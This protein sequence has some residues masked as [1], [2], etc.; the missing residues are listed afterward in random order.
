M[1]PTPGPAWWTCAVTKEPN[2]WGIP[3]YGADTYGESFA[4][5]YDDWYSDLPDHDFIDSIVGALPA[6]P[7]RVLELGVGTGRLVRRW[8]ER[9]STADSIVGVDSSGAMLDL[10]RSHDRGSDV[11]LVLCDFSRELPPGP[12]DVVFVGYNTFF[13]L[14]DH[15][16][17]RRCLR[18][19]A[20]VLAPDGS[21]HL[22]AVHP[23][24]TPEGTVTTEMA[25]PDGTT[26]RSITTHDPAA[27]RITGR[28]VE[29]NDGR[30]GR[31]REWSVRYA[32]PGQ[33]DEMASSVGLVL[34]SRVADGRGTP[35][36]DHS[37]RHVSCWRA[38]AVSF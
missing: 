30:P 1:H 32:T 26:V 31:V 17:M 24:G 10:A 11:E 19:V 38:A 5:V 18:L 6:R 28:F 29:M 36:D 20:D 34:A 13:N 35:F 15:A 3:G 4:D 14:P 21:F 25:R 22:D 12:F 8:R 23:V 37:A 2:P 27:Q 16:S 9:R 7:L 33:L